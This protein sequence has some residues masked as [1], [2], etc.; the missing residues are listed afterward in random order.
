MNRPLQGRRILVTRPAAQAASLA[1]MIAAQGGQAVLFALLEIGP[2][3]DDAALRRAIAQLDDYAVAI[4]ISAN[5]A[6]FSVPQ[7]LAAGGWPKT[8]QAA[9]IGQSTAAQL[10]SLGVEDV[11]CPAARFDSEALLEL[12]ALAAGALAGKKVLLLRGNGGRELLADTLR[13]RGAT[14]DCVTCYRRSGP[15]D[16]PAL[17]LTAWR[18]GQLNALTVSSSEGLRHLLDL[19]DV[20]GRAFLQKTPLFVPHARIAENARALGL[21]KIILT[22][23]ADA[24]LIAGLGAYNWSA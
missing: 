10:A 2:A 8:L 23:A 22:D 4:F 7:I 24:G 5:A 16:G 6:A 19:L 12:P 13:Q 9:A 18:A 15:A 20:E 3:D 17:L 21:E 11:I 1:R 14:V